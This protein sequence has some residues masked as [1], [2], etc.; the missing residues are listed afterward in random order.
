MP[1]NPLPAGKTPADDATRRRLLLGG[2]LLAPALMPLV[3]LALGRPLRLIRAARQQQRDAAA[4][5]LHGL[6]G[7]ARGAGELE[8]HRGGELAAAQQPDPVP[9]LAGEPGRAE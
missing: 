5:G 8:R 6:L 7:G 1:S 9:G 2:S 4:G 3:A